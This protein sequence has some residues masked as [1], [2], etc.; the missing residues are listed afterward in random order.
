MTYTERKRER[1]KERKKRKKKKTIGKQWE[2]NRKK[3][4]KKEKER[5]KGKQKE[6]KEKKKIT[7]NINL[8]QVDNLF[9]DK[10]KLLASK[11][12]EGAEP[13]PCTACRMPA[14][15]S[16]SLLSGPCRQQARE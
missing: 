5:K 2:N 4:E 14:C 9:V 12:S 7:V 6:K 3:K 1:K 13:L 10:S 15:A 16:K 11:N 8:H